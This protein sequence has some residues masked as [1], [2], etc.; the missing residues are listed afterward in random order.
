[1][2]APT[3]HLAAR[4][5]AF[6]AREL[7]LS[8]E[9]IHPASR[10]LEDLGLDGDDAAEFMEAF[11]REF[12]VVL[13]NFPYSRYVGPEGLPLGVPLSFLLVIALAAALAVLTAWWILFFLAA[14]IILYKRYKKP[15]GPPPAASGCATWSRPPRPGAGQITSAYR[16]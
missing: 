9:K 14:L 15:P 12:A 6:T 2:F 16:P 4:V 10:L 8:P 3:D 13:K 11:A 1:L 5:L 7:G